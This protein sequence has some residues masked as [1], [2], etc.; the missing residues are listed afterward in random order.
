MCGGAIISDFVPAVKRGR[1]L[2]TQDL[3]AEL[4]SISDHFGWDCKP[5][6]HTFPS[7]ASSINKITP[8]Q[9]PPKHH[10]EPSGLTQKVS[11]NKPSQRPRK[12]KYRGIRQRPWGKWAA[13]IRDPRKGVR[14]WLG[15]YNTAEEA[16]L[17][18]DAAAK[19]IRGDKAKLN[20][21]HAPPNLPAAKRPCV[22]QDSVLIGMHEP[23]HPAMD[24]GAC[25]DQPICRKVD[26]IG[27]TYELKD[28]IS[29]LESFLGLDDELTQF[30]GI[31]GTESDS[32]DL[33]MMDDL[34][35]GIV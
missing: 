7:P 11:G 18:Y 30:D 29:S 3:W 8:A 31:D 27:D 17:A 12:N 1:K 26:D 20:F 4:D 24:F 6:A 19:R 23:Q 25:Q 34:P 10:K 16:A 35:A 2:T 15:T 5:K 14:V 33:W 22:N 28:Q 21:A 32:V 13:E 9:N